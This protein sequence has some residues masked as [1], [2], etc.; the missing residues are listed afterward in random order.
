MIEWLSAAAIALAGAYIGHLLTRRRE[1]AREA[2]RREFEL[3]MRLLEL[4]G[5]YFGVVSAET[6]GEPFPREL[7]GILRD[8]V[9]QILDLARQIDDLPYIEPLLRAVAG[10]DGFPSATAREKE[11]I[12]LVDE[13][14]RRVNPRYA[15]AMAQVSRENIEHI[16]RGGG[17]SHAP[18]TM[19]YPVVTRRGES[20]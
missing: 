15:R 7:S 12:R 6:Q 13:I 9:M 1:E 2:K 18:A 19:D 17:P 8:R 3:Y 4:N 16:G 10:S 14:G 5:L 20:K 11:M